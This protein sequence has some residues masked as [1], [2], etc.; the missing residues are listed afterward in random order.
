MI[1]LWII[2]NLALIFSV[3]SDSLLP[4]N[5]TMVD[6]KL[7]TNSGSSCGGRDVFAKVCNKV[8]SEC[9]LE[10][11]IADNALAFQVGSTVSST[12]RKCSNFQ[13]ASYEKKLTVSLSNYQQMGVEM[14]LANITLKTNTGVSCGGWFVFAKICNID[15]GKCCEEEIVNNGNSGF[16][17]GDT[18]VRQFQGSCYNLLLTY[19]DSLTIKLTSWEELTVSR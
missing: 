15:S 8:N 3:T 13:V 2:W 6:I 16:D 11:I 19:D 10:E 18:I 4:E 1:K 14:K 17:D 5:K 12:I 9:C 7:F